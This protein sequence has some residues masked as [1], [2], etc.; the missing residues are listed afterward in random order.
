MM[1][2]FIVGFALGMMM[3]SGIILV[4]MHHQDMKDLE[5]RTGRYKQVYLLLLREKGNDRKRVCGNADHLS[6]KCEKRGPL[7]IGN[8]FKYNDH[9]FFQVFGSRLP[10]KSPFLDMVQVSRLMDRQKFE[11]GLRGMVI[12]NK[13]FAT[14]T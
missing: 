7:A 11:L 8:K 4:V 6:Y 1:M 13:R 12:K 14:R 5:N 3:A 2:M 10:V 9:M